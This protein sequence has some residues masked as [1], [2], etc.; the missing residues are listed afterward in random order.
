MNSDEIAE[1]RSR[2]SDVARR[3]NIDT[4]T[5]KPCIAEVIENGRRKGDEPGRER[6]AF[7]IA[8]ELRRVGKDHNLVF[9][10]LQNWNSKNNPSLEIA[11][12]RS[13]AKSA[14]KLKEN[15]EYR[16]NPGCQYEDMQWLCLGDEFRKGLCPFAPRSGK[17]KYTKNRLFLEYGWQNLLG[18][19]AKDIYYIA[20]PELERR[21]GVG[22][23]G[24]V[25]ANYKKI[26]QLAGIT[27]KSVVTALKELR[28][29]PLI[30]YLKTG[31][32][33]RWE[34]KAT[35]IRREIPIPRPPKELLRRKRNG[36]D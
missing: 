26:A 28:E 32:P 35:V 9:G 33:R 10:I 29:T 31:I 20:L 12:L 2:T 3:L 11:K 24:Q 5:L 15:G 36:N 8:C 7:L 30:A 19:A 13:S 21:S 1:A 18:N 27:P 4:G 6:C 16:Y 25:I 17:N 14:F 23:G 34:G 22:A